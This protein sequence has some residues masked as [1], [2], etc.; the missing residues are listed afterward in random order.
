MSDPALLRYG[1]PA[2]STGCPVVASEYGSGVGKEVR[3][4]HV[5]PY[6]TAASSACRF[7]IE[8]VAWVAGPWAVADLTGSNWLAIPTL[9]VLVGLPAVFNAPGD[10][11]T[12]GVLIPGPLRIVIEMLLA[13]VAIAASAIVWPTWAAVAVALIAVAMLVT[14]QSR[15]RWLA[16]GAPA[17]ELT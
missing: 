2:T 13:A 17:V 14:G 10:K 4:N 8:I 1:I 6:D 5:S 15:Y 11:N 7:L 16:S 9:V 12:D 3:S